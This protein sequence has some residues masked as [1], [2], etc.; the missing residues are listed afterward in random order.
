MNNLATEHI[1]QHLLRK[2]TITIVARSDS[3]RCARAPVENNLKRLY[4][5]KMSTS[6]N[7]PKTAED[8]TS[9]TYHL[10]GTSTQQTGCSWCQW[11]VKVHNTRNWVVDT[12]CP[13]KTGQP[14]RL[15]IQNARMKHVQT[16]KSNPS[17]R[18]VQRPTALDGPYPEKPERTS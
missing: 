1:S 2:L 16:L 11:Q 3:N 18:P 4:T 15:R 6:C 12:R 13:E 5:H 17:P 8:G 14:T 10:I 9:N 7:A